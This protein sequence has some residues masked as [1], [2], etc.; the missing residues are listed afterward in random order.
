MFESVRPW[1]SKWGD[2]VRKDIGRVRN[3]L[4]ALFELDGEDLTKTGKR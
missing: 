2:R 1:W 3:I 4:L